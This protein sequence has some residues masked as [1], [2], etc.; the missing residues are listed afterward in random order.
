METQRDTA[1]SRTKR[2][3]IGLSVVM[4]MILAW[5]SIA[6][7]SISRP[8]LSYEL[9]TI[10][11]LE[12]RIHFAQGIVQEAAII[13]RNGD[14]I[15]DYAT[16]QGLSS[17]KVG[18]VGPFLGPELSSGRNEH[19]RFELKV[20]YGDGET[21]PSYLCFATPMDNPGLKSFYIYQT[22]VLRYETLATPGPESPTHQL[23]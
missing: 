3:L 9:D 6:L 2:I 20:V 17:V 12:K 15:G 23:P 4:F 8:S 19:Y 10:Q 5:A 14:G 21:L 11:D 1:K 16:L 22:G 13:D 18:S 7:P